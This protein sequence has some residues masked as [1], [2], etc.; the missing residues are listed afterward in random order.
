MT[1]KQYEKNQAQ[2]DTMI[3]PV[4]QLATKAC[5]LHV[6]EVCHKRLELATKACLFLILKSREQTLEV[7]GDFLASTQVYK[8]P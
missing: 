2:D 7:R 4:V 3:Y 8:P 5:L 6:V 1:S